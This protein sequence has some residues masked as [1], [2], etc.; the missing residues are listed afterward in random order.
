MFEVTRKNFIV[1]GSAG[2]SKV[3]NDIIKA[4]G[5]KIVALFDSSLNAQAS[6]PNVPLYYGS[7]GLKLWIEGNSFGDIVGA[8]AI[9]GAKGKSRQEI[10]ER[11]IGYGI[12]MPPLVHLTASISN[13]AL[14]GSGSHI[15]ANTVIAA[16]VVIGKYCI[17]NNSANIDH[18]TIIENGSH[19]APGAILC[20]CVSI[21]ENTLIGAGAI[22]LPRIKIGR[23]VTVGAG[24]VVTKNVPDDAIVVGNPAMDFKKGSVND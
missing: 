24:A 10:A 19:I 2:H 23:N 11:L 6:I 8:I 18:E 20:G 13:S 21:G 12:Y 22:I 3:L 4:R 7:N 9:G 15:L 1:W 17:V 5:G 14:I 16:E